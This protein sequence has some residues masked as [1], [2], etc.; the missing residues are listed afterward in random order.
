MSVTGER[1]SM[2]NGKLQVPANPVIP[3]IIPLLLLARTVHRANPS[4]GTNRQG[5][6]STMVHGPLHRSRTFNDPTF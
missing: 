5:D 2:Q 6:H 1:I 4:R 3:F